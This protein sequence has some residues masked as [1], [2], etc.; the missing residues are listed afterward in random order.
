[1]NAS[2][3]NENVTLT[4]S[5]STLQSQ[6]NSLQTQQT[7][8]QL[9]NSQLVAEKD[10][11]LKK[12]QIQNTQHD[13]LLLDQMTLRSLH[14]QLSTEYE[15]AKNEQ[16][17][18]K[19]I[20]RDL[21]S[22]IRGMK[23]KN[24][25]LQSRIANLEI[26]K[27]AMKNEAKNLAHLKGEHMKLK[28]DFRNLFTAS[29]RMKQEYKAVQEELKNLK[30]EARNLRLGQTEMQGELNSRSDRMAGL[31]LE[32]AKLQQKCDM[33]FEMNHSLDSDRRALMEHVSQLL[34]QYHSLLT[35][36]LEDKQHFHI[37]EKLYT[38]KLNNL[39]RQ[40]EK[41]EEKIMDHYR[42]LDNAT[43][44]KKGFGATL[45]RRVR[46]AGSDIINKVPSR[47]R[48]S[49]HEDGASQL[50]HSQLTL[51]RGGAIVGGANA[52][53]A[54]S[55]AE[56]NSDNSSV[57]DPLA[58][59]GGA[60]AGPPSSSPLQSPF[61]SRNAPAGGSLH[62]IKP[63]DEVALL[64]RA[65]LRDTLPHRNS[66]A[67]DQKSSAPQIP[68][69]TQLSSNV[70]LSYTGLESSSQVNADIRRI[71][72]W[73]LVNKVQFNVQKTRAT[74]LTKKSHVRL[75]T[76]EMEER[77]LV[78]SPSIKLLGIS[79]NRNMSWHD[80]VATI[81]KTAFQ[82]LE[83][84]IQPSL[85][86]CSHMQGCAPKHSLKLLDSVEK[87]AGRLI[88]APNHTKDLH[89]LEYRRRLAVAFIYKNSSC[90]L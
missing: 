44:K 1:M 18:L 77:P 69:L 17:N 46:K 35:H 2:L 60:S 10:E 12:Q 38:D 61:R 58:L 7:A 54:G 29:D 87:R 47:N 49:W 89:S 67:G 6:I 71:V 66:I 22:E 39:C 90:D 33:L 56:S 40:K 25:S 80:H 45:V 16:E 9:A 5:V 4:V 55:G 53:V 30:I 34:S 86:Y 31:Q 43:S 84:Q 68:A 63:R 24:N 11:L 52:S 85:E 59:V 74:T 3:Q 73:G 64:R 26:E 65:G 81:A 78:E 14:E 41:L 32:N 82:K 13:T 48:R 57:E 62:G 8:L 76:V 70:E 79:V 20:S 28:D 21:R 19:K 83:A 36:S 50:S 72:E 88:E 15:Q 42:K 27:E 75:P 51:L 23:E 37:E